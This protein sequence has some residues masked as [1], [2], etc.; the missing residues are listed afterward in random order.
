[1]NAFVKTSEKTE[2]LRK[3]WGEIIAHIASF[4]FFGPPNWIIWFP[5]VK[6]IYS[7]NFALFWGKHLISPFLVGTALPNLGEISQNTY[8]LSQNVAFLVYAL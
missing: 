1:M 7:P 4:D 3:F 8:V 6:V 5:H 2:Y